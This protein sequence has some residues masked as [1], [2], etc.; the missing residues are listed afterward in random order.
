MLSGGALS[1]ATFSGSE[2]IFL[3]G[4]PAKAGDVLLNIVRKSFEAY[5]RFIFKG[6]VEI[7]VS[8]LP[9]NDAAI[10]GTAALVKA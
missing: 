1:P 2:A 7:R 6:R 10:L 8:E 4:G 3:F 5:L 9:D